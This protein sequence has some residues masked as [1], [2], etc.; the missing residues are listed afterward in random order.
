MQ[1]PHLPQT[2]ETRMSELRATT[3]QAAQFV[4]AARVAMRQKELDKAYR[5]SLEATRLDPSNVDGW[6][7]RARSA[8][9]SDERMFALSRVHLLN[10]DHPAARAESYH[11]RWEML[12]K[13]PFLAYL[14]ET[15]DLYY[16]R[17]YAYASLPVPKDRNVPEVYPPKQPSPLLPA[18]NYLWLAILGMAFAGIGTLVFAPLAMLKAIRINRRELTRPDRVRM[19]VIFLVSFLMLIPAL[20]LFSIFITHMR[21]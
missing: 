11:L 20:V 5:F 12:K 1:T 2:D 6:L 13:E 8:D 9:S 4:Q 7:I 19:R 18:Y 16:V 14:S 10:P 17:N 15:D 3:A 21:G